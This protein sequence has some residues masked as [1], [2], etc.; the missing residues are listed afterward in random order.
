VVGTA[1]LLRSV[2]NDGLRKAFERLGEIPN[3]ADASDD[4]KDKFNTWRQLREGDERGSVDV[5]F[6]LYNITNPFEVVAGTQRPVVAEVGPYVYNPYYVRFDVS[7]EKDDTEVSFHTQTYYRHNAAL[8][9]PRRESDPIFQGWLA[10]LEMIRQTNVSSQAQLE[11]FVTGPAIEG[12]CREAL[13]IVRRSFNATVPACGRNESQ[14][15]IFFS[16]ECWEVAIA[17]WGEVGS[18]AQFGLPATALDSLLILRGGEFLA[19]RVRACAR[20][21]ADSATSRRLREL[22]A[23]P[24]QLHH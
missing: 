11:S 24:R 2:I 1:F 16:D 22:L 18:A 12:W 8:T 21:L 10:Y 14:P 19:L 5:R 6:Y 23:R 3:P 15:E 9:S 7:F 4:D 20:A 13:K 17:N